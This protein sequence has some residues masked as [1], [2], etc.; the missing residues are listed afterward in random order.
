M[1]KEGISA[2]L[3]RGTEEKK[4]GAKRK[5][6]GRDRRKVGVFHPPVSWG[7]GNIERKRKEIKSP[8]R[9]QNFW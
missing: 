1:C 3:G 4:G 7:S 6:P 9:K 2:A 5:T 8:G